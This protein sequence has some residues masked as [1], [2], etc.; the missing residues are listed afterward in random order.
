MGW[1]IADWILLAQDEKE[2]SIYL[3]FKYYL[4]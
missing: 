2:L 4:A 1:G 3:K